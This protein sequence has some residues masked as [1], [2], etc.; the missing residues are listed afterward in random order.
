MDI[1]QN[2]DGYRLHELYAMLKA[3]SGADRRRV[4]D[5]IDARIIKIGSEPK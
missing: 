3:A 5:A 4:Q 1:P 2:L